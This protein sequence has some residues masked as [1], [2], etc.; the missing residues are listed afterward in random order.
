MFTKPLPSTD[1]R[2]TLKEPSPWNGVRDTQS[3]RLMG[4]I[5]EVRRRDGLRWHSIYM[6]N[7]LGNQTVSRNPRDRM[8]LLKKFRLKIIN[9]LTTVYRGSGDAPQS[10]LDLDI[11]Q[12]RCQPR[13][14]ISLNLGKK[15]SRLPINN[16]VYGPQSRSGYSGEDE[17]ICLRGE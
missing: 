1:W 12:S 4:G 7:I 6:R 17:N 15:A 5:Y 8:C 2:D 14:V 16:N 11:R 9:V 13:S 10:A 3:H